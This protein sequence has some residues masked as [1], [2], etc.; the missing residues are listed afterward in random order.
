MTAEKKERPDRMGRLRLLLKKYRYA[1]V[2]LLVGLVLL[3]L[4]SGKSA[5]AGTQSSAQAQ[6]TFDLDGMEQKLSDSLSKVAGAGKVQVVLTLKNGGRKVL[7]TD[8]STSS[9]SG[10][11]QQDRTTVVVSQ[12]SS[13]QA[14]VELQ[15]IY[16]QFQGALI[17]CPGG[18]DAAVRL[19]LA[20]A[21]S[22]LTGLGTDKISICKG[23]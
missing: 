23:T 13:Q 14:P 18:D 1:G 15:Q 6:E 2:I 10:T 8:V 3:A 4:P 22:A 9:D 17:I 7:A 5:G 20:E 12:G 16:P 21:V 19:K 11:Y